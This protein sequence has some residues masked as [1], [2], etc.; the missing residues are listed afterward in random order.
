M[1][2][3]KLQK[4]TTVLDHGYFLKIEHHEIVLPDGKVISDWPVVKTPDYVNILARDT[5]GRFVLFRQTKYMAPSMRLAPPGGYLE[6]GEDPLIAAQREL[7]EETGYTAPQWIH[8]GSFIVDSNR[9]CGTAHLYLALDAVWTTN[10]HSDDL[11]EQH[12]I[13]MH[14]PELEQDF[15][16][17]CPILSATLLFALAFRHL[18]QID[19]SKSR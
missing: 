3:W 9:G 11:E 16:T 6:P 8:L 19:P 5:T 14:R 13:L 7:L 15:T 18:D 2:D 1:T 17:A 10:I 4:R 12:L